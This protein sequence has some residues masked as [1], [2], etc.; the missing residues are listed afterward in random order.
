MSEAQRE[1]KAEAAAACD[2]RGDSPEPELDDLAHHKIHQPRPPDEVCDWQG[3]PPEPEFDDLAHDLGEPQILTKFLGTSRVEPPPPS[4]AEKQEDEAPADRD[5]KGKAHEEPLNEKGPEAAPVDEKPPIKDE[6]DKPPDNAGE[7]TLQEMVTHGFQQALDVFQNIIKASSPQPGNAE[8]SE[9]KK[10]PPDAEKEPP[11]PP[12]IAAPKGKKSK[13]D[14]E[15]EKREKEEA[16]KAEKE[17]KA[18]EKEEK[19]RLKKEKEL[20]RKEQRRKEKEKKKNKGKE[21]DTAPADPPINPDDSA[22]AD[23]HPHP[24]CHLC[25]HPQEQGTIDFI[26]ESLENWQGLPSFEDLAAAAKKFLGMKSADEPQDIKQAD[27]ESP[28]MSDQELLQHIAEHIE[29]H[30]QEYMDPKAPR[31]ENTTTQEAPGESSKHHEVGENGSPTNHGLDGNRDSPMT[32]IQGH[33]LRNLELTTNTDVVVTQP[34]SRTYTP[35]RAPMSRCVSPWCEHLG[36][37]ID[38][39]PVPFPKRNSTWPRRGYVT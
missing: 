38:D 12:A 6:E 39:S 7:E 24:G 8:P 17:R 18:K 5:Y 20:E 22:P 16:K 2:W 26:R 21:T 9:P 32:I 25:K 36:I 29:Q 28:S 10:P 1:A 37:K 3:D 23:L 4:E 13:E 27:N 11:E 34:P 14:K 31:E 30:I 15:R 35:F 19:K 33:L